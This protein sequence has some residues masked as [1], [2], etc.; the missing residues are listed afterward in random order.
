ML[1]TLRIRNFVLIEKLELD[2]DRGFNVITGETG[3]GKSIILDAIALILGGRAEA[4]LIRA[5]ADEA[6]VEALFDVAAN[7]A[8]RDKL[9]AKGVTTDEGGELLVRR[10]I[11]RGGKNRIFINDELVTLAQLGELAENLVDLC[12]QHEHQSLARAAY[13]LD[14]LDRYA[15]LIALKKTVREYFFALRSLQA[16]LTQVS[17][18]DGSEARLAD[19]IQ[20]QIQEIDAF[21][22]RLGEEE[23]LARERKVLL[24]VTHLMEACAGANA[25]L[26]GGDDDSEGARTLL[27]KAVRRMEKAC[28]TDATLAPAREALGRALAELDEA[29]SQI[30]GYAQRLQADPRRFD[31][32]EE[33]LS[34]L[35]GLKK[36]Y[37]GSEASIMETRNRLGTELEQW[38]SRGVRI[39]RLEKSIAEARGA[40]YKAAKE[41]SKKRRTVAKTLA[42][43][44]QAEL[45]ELRMGGA[46]FETRFEAVSEDEATWGPEGIDA[47]ELRF[48]PNVGE[49]FSPLG[50]IASGGELSRVMLAIRRVVAD[51]GGICV[52][53]FDEIDAGIGG[54]TASVV[55]RKI[56]SV[57][58][59]NQVI[60]ITHLPQISA[61]ADAH[62]SVSKKVES[63]R[64]SSSIRRLEEGKRVE[65]IAR[66]LGGMD[67]TTK[68]R[69]HAKELLSRAQLVE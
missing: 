18:D 43:S 49:G 7:P 45:D 2:F 1:Q 69:D 50:K 36:K 10:N 55:G 32:V 28:E 38:A 22:L 8:V 64:T 19:F 17:G 11:S 53:L 35:V 33:R 57:S 30:G 52:Y 41:L 60:C 29:S 9:T 61:F 39:E 24:S 37:G 40:Y 58:K 51:R 34:K 13:Q 56:Q 48:A 65:E 23:E 47:M 68:S 4:S 26:D 20:F 5:G 27:Q 21:A 3:A 42:S 66:M 63:G 44:I 16:E 6:V 62:F 14:M 59:H 46:R 25:L 12:S 15:G 67:V 54:Q 31:V